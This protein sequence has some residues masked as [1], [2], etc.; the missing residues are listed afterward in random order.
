MNSNKNFYL[1]N[2]KEDDSIKVILDI[3]RLTDN[4]FLLKKTDIS[5]ITTIMIS[6][7]TGYYAFTQEISNSNLVK[8]NYFN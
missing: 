6:Y 4:L 3:K 5:S 8:V 2:S 7:F 1:R